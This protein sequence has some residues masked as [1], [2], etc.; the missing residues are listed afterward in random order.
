MIW[1]APN[2]GANLPTPQP[3]FLKSFALKCV[4]TFVLGTTN[5]RNLVFPMALRSTA[6]MKNSTRY[7]FPYD[8]L[9]YSQGP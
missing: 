4:P 6:K 2:W 1:L 7:H 8:V 5:Q 9:Q 3:S